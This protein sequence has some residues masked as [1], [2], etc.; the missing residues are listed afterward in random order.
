MSEMKQTD[1]SC[2]TNC[3]QCGFCIEVCPTYREKF[4]ESYA[5]RGRV[6]LGRELSGDGR[7]TAADATAPLEQCLM[8]GA[9]EAACPSGVTYTADLA[10]LRDDHADVWRQS[11]PG[12]LTFY[13]TRVVLGPRLLRFAMGAVKAAVKSGLASMM[14]ALFF[15]KRHREHFSKLVA[16]VKQYQPRRYAALHSEV[17]NDASD[18]TIFRGCVT[19]AFFPGVIDAWLSLLS[20][21]SVKF[22]SP[23]QQGC[24]GALHYHHGDLERS[25]TLARKNIDAFKDV[26]GPI[27]VE[28]SGCGAMLKRYGELLADDSDYCEPAAEFSA[29]VMDAT[30]HL[31]DLLAPVGKQRSDTPNA[32]SPAIASDGTG[33][34]VRLTF[35]EPCHLRNLQ[36]ADPAWRLLRAIGAEAHSA[37]ETELCCGSAGI[38]NL[39]EPALA[40]SLGE[41]KADALAAKGIPLVVT[42]NPGCRI[43]LA[44]RLAQRGIKMEHLLETV[45]G[46]FR[47][48][49]E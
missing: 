32:G 45:A 30:A 10:R 16:S 20:R 39:L 21:R 26:T 19:P 43:Q 15:P 14:V 46:H 2:F 49:E 11:Y 29:R 22:S 34:R 31:A 24:C 36:S 47:E 6:I 7:I 35:Q 25:R 37:A 23:R 33:A 38:Y 42:T 3:I 27:L 9:C 12:W 40:A 13:M 5:P 44:G 4:Q 28:A 8:C 1:K 41:R 18:V 17:D 48:D